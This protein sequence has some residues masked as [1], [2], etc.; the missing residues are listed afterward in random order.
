M[1]HIFIQLIIPMLYHRCT[2]RKHHLHSQGRISRGIPLINTPIQDMHP[3]PRTA[4]SPM[5][6]VTTAILPMSILTHGSHQ[7]PGAI[8][9]C[10]VCL[11]L[12]LLVLFSSCSLDWA[13]RLSC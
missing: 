4:M 12:H 9:T 8:G 2:H 1:H 6:K 11:L 10:L 5:G 7:S 3:F 13:A